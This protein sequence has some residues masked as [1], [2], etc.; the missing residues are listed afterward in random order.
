MPAK[1]KDS[2]VGKVRKRNAA[3]RVVKEGCEGEKK[4]VDAYS[5]GRNFL[6]RLKNVPRSVMWRIERELFD[7]NGPHNCKKWN[8]GKVAEYKNKKGWFCIEHFEH[9]IGGTD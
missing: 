2:P 3:S 8:C 9:K 5:A 1:R 6:A 7:K 4:G